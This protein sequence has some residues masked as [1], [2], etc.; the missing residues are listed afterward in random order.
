MMNYDHDEHCHSRRSRNNDGKI[1]CRYCK[2]RFEKTCSPCINSFNIGPDMETRC[3]ATCT[4]IA[5]H[6]C[7]VPYFCKVCQ[8][9]FETKSEQYNGVHGFRP[10]G[11][12]IANCSLW[13]GT[14]TLGGDRVY[15]R[16][17]GREV[18]K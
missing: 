8:Q 2:N 5:H 13:V 14:D 1:K 7:T 9:R 17:S 11:G 16:K 15:M 18:Y 4:T 12:Q 10:N 3:G 6:T